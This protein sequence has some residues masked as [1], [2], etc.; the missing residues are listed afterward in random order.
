MVSSCH[1]GAILSSWVNHQFSHLQLLSGWGYTTRIKGAPLP[2]KLQ[3]A[4]F[5]SLTNDECNERGHSVG[6]KEIC[7]FKLGKG[8]CNGD[9]VSWCDD[10]GHFL[11]CVIEL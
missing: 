11:V 4:N 2:S 1:F 6:P 10:E 5:T 3:V 7:A 8:A 9:S